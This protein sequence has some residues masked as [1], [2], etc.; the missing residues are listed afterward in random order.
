MTKKCNTIPLAKVPTTEA[1]QTHSNWI[2]ITHYRDSN[3]M[4]AVHQLC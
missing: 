2:H 4:E 3:R 1:V